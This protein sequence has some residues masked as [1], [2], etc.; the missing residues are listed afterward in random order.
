MLS[1]V[2]AHVYDQ[3]EKTEMIELLGEENIYPES[4]RLLYSSKRALKDANDWL[5]DR[6]ANEGG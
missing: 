1:G 4:S 3:L 2:S 6:R 5:A